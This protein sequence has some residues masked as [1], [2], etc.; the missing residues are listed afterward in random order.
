MR[1][2]QAFATTFIGAAFLNKQVLHFEDYY[3]EE[4]TDGIM[5]ALLFEPFF[6]WRMDLLSI[7]DSFKLYCISSAEF[8]FTSEMLYPNIKIRLRL[9]KAKPN[10]HKISDHP[11][12][13]L[14][15]FDCSIYTRINHLEL[16]YHKKVENACVYS[17]GVQLSEDSSKVVIFSLKTKPIQ[18]TIFFTFL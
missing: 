4:C 13:S 16:N 11:S 12:S 18:S 14:G 17:R 3:F 15:I 6:T 7:H 9:I 1:T 10:C 5:D 2:Y 8:F